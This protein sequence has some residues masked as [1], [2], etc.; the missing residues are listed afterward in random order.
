EMG[1]QLRGQSKSLLVVVRSTLVPGT[2]RSVVL[3]LLEKVSGMKA[4]HHLDLVFH[5]EFLREGSSVKDFYNPP[6]IVV[7]ERVPG[8][9]DLLLSL[10]EGFAAPVFRTTYETAEMVKFCD[11]IFHALKITFANEIAHFCRAY[12]IDSREV[13]DIFCSD[14][15]LNLSAKYLR[16]GFAFG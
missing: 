2:M 10:Y 12:A 16:P 14:T 13:M 5:P 7:G 11:N 8:S 4:G 1:A 3:P 15:Q 9:A 6:R